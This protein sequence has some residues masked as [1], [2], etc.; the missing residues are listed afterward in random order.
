MS[1]DCTKCSGRERR[2][3]NATVVT[4]VKKAKAAPRVR[5][6]TSGGGFKGFF[7]KLYNWSLIDGDVFLESKDWPYLW[8]K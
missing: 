4:E 2:K 5:V 6:K 3:M 8:K 1:L 7:K